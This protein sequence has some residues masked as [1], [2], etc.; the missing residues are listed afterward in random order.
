MYVNTEEAA[1]RQQIT[2]VPSQM[3]RRHRRGT[4]PPF[5]RNIC[6]LG[7]WSNTITDTVRFFPSGTD[8][9]YRSVRTCVFFTYVLSI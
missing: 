7:D 2:N 9:F 3:Y 6:I 1:R 4:G 8:D 5:R